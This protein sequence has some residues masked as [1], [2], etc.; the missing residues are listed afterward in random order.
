VRRGEAGGL[1]AR[2]W[3]GATAGGRRYLARS[4]IGSWHEVT[5]SDT[6]RL[7]GGEVA[8]VR[9]LMVSRPR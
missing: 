5:G 4:W 1:V 8:A 7:M 6:L 3:A 2:A 9:R